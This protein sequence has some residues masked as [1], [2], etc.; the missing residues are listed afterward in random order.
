MN[1][2][3]WPV[4]MYRAVNMRAF[5]SASVGVF[6]VTICLAATQA[7]AKSPVPPGVHIDPG[8]P[9]A[10]QYQIPIPA[11]RQETSGGTGPSGGGNANPPLFGV[12]VSSPPS[13]P[14]GRH[15]APSARHSSRRTRARSP[16]LTAPQA[17][18]GAR[19]SPGSSSSLSTGA[20]K[21]GQIGSNGWV[22][23]VVGGGLVLLL[24]GGGGLGLRRR[25]LRT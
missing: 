13:R 16:R 18:R 12:G 5:A 1:A 22:P 17:S 3:G 19:R 23:L 10:K 24:G 21:A 14:S 4:V 20:D 6:V 7:V 2:A 25:Y 11:A 8:S 9:A 15:A